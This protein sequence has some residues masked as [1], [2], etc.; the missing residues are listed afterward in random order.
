MDILTIIRQRHDGEEDVTVITQDAVLSTFDR[1]FTALNL[2]VSGI[3]V[4]SLLVAGILIMNV[5]LVSVSQR[6]QEIGLLKALGTPARQI[7]LLFLTEA[8][9]LSLCGALL[10]T[11]FGLSANGALRHAFPDFVIAPPPGR[12]ASPS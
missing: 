4:I 3:A 6:R 8:A 7:L 1:I 5:M 12:W 2:T 11:I 10:G 9:L